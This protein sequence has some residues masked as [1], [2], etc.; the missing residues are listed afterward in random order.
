MHGA[1]PSAKTAPSTG[2]PARPARGR[3]RDPRL[4][5]GADAEEDQAHRDDDQPAQAHEQRAVLDER[6]GR[7]W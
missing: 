5:L 4:A 3:Q 6:R 2:A 7:P 1:Q